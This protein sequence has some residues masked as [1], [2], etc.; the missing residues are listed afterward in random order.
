MVNDLKARM[1]FAVSGAEYKKAEGI[2][3]LA[4]QLAF[5]GTIGFNTASAIVQTAQ[6]PMVVM[7]MMMAKYGVR[8]TL[9]A[10][11]RAMRIVTSARNHRPETM[12][13]QNCQANIL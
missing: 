1:K 8:P 6:I 4:N 11:Y 7:P 5:V 2:A 13:F 10:M 12:D 3:R 9:Q